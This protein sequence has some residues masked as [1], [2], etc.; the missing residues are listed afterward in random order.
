[1]TLAI[2]TTTIIWCRQKNH[3]SFERKLSDVDA[4]VETVEI[5]KLLLHCNRS[6][7]CDT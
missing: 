4:T 7:H 5:I 2:M 1:M 3:T 6:K